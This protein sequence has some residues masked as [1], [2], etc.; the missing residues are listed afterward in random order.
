ML[1]EK[2]SKGLLKITTQLEVKI[3]EINE[4][5]QTINKIKSLEDFYAFRLKISQSFFELD[6][7]IR[8]ILQNIKDFRLQMKELISEK[9]FSDLKYKNLEDKYLNSV[10]YNEELKKNNRELVFQINLQ[11]E[12]IFK[13]ENL[14]LTLTENQKKI[15]VA[16]NMNENTNRSKNEALSAKIINSTSDAVNKN[17][18]VFINKS[19]FNSVIAI[20]EIKEDEKIDVNDIVY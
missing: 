19:N 13:N 4:T 9:Q 20:K 7:E 10:K 15:E 17:N 5:R 14:V 18:N 1:T 12:E 8:E 6:Q 3:K 2:S 11:Q 16:N